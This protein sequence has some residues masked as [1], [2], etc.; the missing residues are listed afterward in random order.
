[1]LKLHSL[2]FKEC[3]HSFEITG[4]S[5]LNIDQRNKNKIADYHTDTTGLALQCVS[6][7][8]DFL[9]LFLLIV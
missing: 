5:T 7:L 2:N 4:I 9:N 8:K 3:K 1:M 6:S